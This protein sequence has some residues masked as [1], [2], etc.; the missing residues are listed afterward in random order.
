MKQTFRVLTVIFSIFIIAG[1]LPL[2]AQTGGNSS[3]G[4]YKFGKTNL[5][6]EYI[7]KRLTKKTRLLQ[8]YLTVLV[9]KKEPDYL[10]A[11]DKAMLLFNN[12]E[13]KLISVSNKNNKQIAVKPIKEYLTDISKLR[14]KSVNITYVNYTAINNIHRQPDG[15]Y[16]G[17]VV[18][19][20]E[21]SGYDNEGKAM[22]NDVIQ[23]D[24]EVTIKIREYTKN[25]KHIDVVD[26]FF[27]NIGVFEM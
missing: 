4:D 18:F 26:I 7:D 8:H 5:H 1:P 12:D 10:K 11:L 23:R 27:G 15:T 19:Q 2:A 25:N 3:K 17:I 6:K 14:Y 24:M 22:Y 9:E 16:R 21:F 20:Q 13:T